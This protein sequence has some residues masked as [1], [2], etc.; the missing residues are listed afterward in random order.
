ML[1]LS[2][3]AGTSAAG[4]AQSTSGELRLQVPTSREPMSRVFKKSSKKGR[5]SK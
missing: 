4:Q 2:I 5:F 1:W 3:V